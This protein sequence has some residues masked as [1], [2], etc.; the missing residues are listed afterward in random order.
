MHNAIHIC[1][2]IK[3]GG[4]RKPHAKGSLNHGNPNNNSMP[5]P[6]KIRNK[7]HCTLAAKI[8]KA[9]RKTQFTSPKHQR[10]L[11]HLSSPPASLTSYKPVALSPAHF[12]L[13]RLTHHVHNSHAG[14][15]EHPSA[16]TCRR[17]EAAEVDSLLVVSSSENIGNHWWV[18]AGRDCPAPNKD[19]PNADDTPSLR[20]CK[21]P[22]NSR[23]V[24]I[25]WS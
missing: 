12:A 21:P 19:R 25:H 22:N 20:H 17:L 15:L 7:K 11:P 23:Q 3:S 8:H 13:C 6:K 16:A 14:H 4:L 5:P 24:T 10:S 18:T 2:E 9:T 1:I